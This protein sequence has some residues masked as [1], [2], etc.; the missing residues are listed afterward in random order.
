MKEHKVS[1]K[2]VSFSFYLDVPSS[3]LLEG[4]AVTAKSGISSDCTDRNSF[5]A[6]A[7]LR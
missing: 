1:I 2:V 4:T 3:G 5:K 6:Y 7:S